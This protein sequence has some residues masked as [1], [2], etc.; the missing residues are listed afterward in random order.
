VHI[1]G[2]Q[3]TN[4][5]ADKSALLKPGEKVGVVREEV[6][7][8]KSAPG[9][10][11]LL[12]QVRSAVDKNIMDI[13]ASIAASLYRQYGIPAREPSIISRCTYADG[14]RELCFTFSQPGTNGLC[15]ETRVSASE[16]GTIKTVAS[17]KLFTN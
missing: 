8:R 9:K 13:S 6:I 1:G 14:R 3:A 7:S 11:S 4:Y 15:N 17:T 2:Y 10:Q 12:V 5:T 16:D